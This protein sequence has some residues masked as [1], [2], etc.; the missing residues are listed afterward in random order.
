MPRE[1]RHRQRGE[2]E[3]QRERRGRAVGDCDRGSG[4]A[5]GGRRGADLD[6]DSETRRRPRVTR[7]HESL[8]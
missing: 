6:D 3:N 1:C 4:R 7:V 8:P 2:R 5:G